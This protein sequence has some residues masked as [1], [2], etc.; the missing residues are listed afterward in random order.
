M[1]AE[2]LDP[3]AFMLRHDLD[4][5]DRAEIELGARASGALF[6]DAFGA[7]YSDVKDRAFAVVLHC[8]SR[9]CQ[10]PGISDEEIARWEPTFDEHE[11]WVMPE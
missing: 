5:W 11:S 9:V 10:T 7:L 8:Y 3:E 4:E 2:Y 1:S 6:A